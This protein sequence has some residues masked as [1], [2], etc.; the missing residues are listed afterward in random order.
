MLP[1]CQAEGGELDAE[2]FNEKLGPTFGAGLSKAALAQLFMKIDADC[3]GTVDW[4]ACEIACF[5]DTAHGTHGNEICP[6]T[7]VQ[8]EKETCKLAS[9]NAGTSSPT[10]SS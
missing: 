8:A 5:R 10:T 9:H 3:G 2:S 1:I 4:C 6:V 7:M